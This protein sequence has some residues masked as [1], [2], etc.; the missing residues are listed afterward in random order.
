MTP[1]FTHTYTQEHGHCTIRPP[2]EVFMRLVITRAED[3]SFKKSVLTQR[4]RENKPDSL[5]VS[6]RHEKVIRHPLAAE[7]LN[8]S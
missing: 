6:N 4:F 7:H 3:V 1:G 8:R 2:Y 5:I